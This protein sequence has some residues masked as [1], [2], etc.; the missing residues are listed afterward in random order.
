[1]CGVR[2]ELQ[3]AS[4]LQHARAY[5]HGREATP[6]RAMWQGLFAQDAAE[7]AS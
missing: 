1:M 5:T 6:V 3:P 2:Q 7:A 4:G